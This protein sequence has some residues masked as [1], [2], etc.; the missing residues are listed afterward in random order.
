MPL[1]NDRARSLTAELAVLALVCEKWQ[2][3]GLTGLGVVSLF[4]YFFLLGMRPGYVVVTDDQARVIHRSALSIS[5]LPQYDQPT[6]TFA[7]AH[8]RRLW[9][10]LK[11]RRG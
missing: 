11:P 4:H 6:Q 5:G 7:G 3:W 1:L 8:I 2:W 9:V 10:A